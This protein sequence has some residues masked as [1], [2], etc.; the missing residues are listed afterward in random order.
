MKGW[1]CL[2]GQGVASPRVTPQDRGPP[3][4]IRCCPQAP[5]H[6]LAHSVADAGPRWRKERCVGSM[7][8]QSRHTAASHSGRLQEI[9]ARLRLECSWPRTRKVLSSCTRARRQ[10]LPAIRTA[11]SSAPNSLGLHFFIYFYI[12]TYAK[13][14]WYSDSR[15][16]KNDIC[17]V[18]FVSRQ[19]ARRTLVT[20]VRRRGG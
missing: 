7:D 19:G 9:R 18:S 8:S 6:H 11:G 16:S 20:N 17:Q 4:R 2:Y 5:G 3:R 14:D 13:L 1:R 15:S 10:I 12:L